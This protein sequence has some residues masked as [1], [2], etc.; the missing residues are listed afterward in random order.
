MDKSN[1]NLDLKKLK[2][3][4][5]FGI[6]PSALQCM[7]KH[8]GKDDL[9]E[10]ILALFPVVGKKKEYEPLTFCDACM[11]NIGIND[12][13]EFFR[14]EG[15]ESSMLSCKDAIEFKLDRE[16]FR[17]K[18]DGCDSFYKEDIIWIR[19]YKQDEI[20]PMFLLCT[21]HKDVKIK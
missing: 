12:T 15:S 21:E 14:E 2:F 1:H 11:D 19:V 17:C 3:F 5:S 6:I 18:V 10:V 13:I 4:A 8:C 16:D 9:E 7:V 20:Y